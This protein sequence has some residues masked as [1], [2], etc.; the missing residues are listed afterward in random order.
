MKLLP[1]RRAVVLAI[2]VF[3]FLCNQPQTYAQTAWFS[4]DRLTHECLE[5]EGHVYFAI[6]DLKVPLGLSVIFDGE[7]Y[8]VGGTINGTL[9]IDPDSN[10]L[11]VDSGR[12]NFEVPVISRDGLLYLPD[13]LLEAAFGVKVAV[14]KESGEVKL[15]SQVFA[16]TPS[17]D[18][19]RISSSIP[20]TFRT[21]ELDSP[22]R[23]VIDISGAFLRGQMLNVPGGVLGITGLAALR[24][25]QFA[26]EPPV[27]RV[28]LEWEPDSPP[29]HTLF[30]ESKSVAVLVGQNSRPSTSNWGTN[31][32]AIT[33]PEPEIEPVEETVDPGQ[34]D[35]TSEQTF[36]FPFPVNPDP[37]VPFTNP[38]SP[39]P[40]LGPEVPSG[41]SQEMEQPEEPLQTPDDFPEGA[42]NLSLTELGWDF[43]FELDSSGEL[44]ASIGTPPFLSL[45]EFTLAGEGGMRLVINLQGTWLPGD[46][47]A[48]EG[49]Q[50][51]DRIRI[52]QFEQTITRIVLDLNRVVAYQLEFD[53]WEGAITVRLLQGDLSGKTIVIDPGHGGVDPGATVGSVRESD[54][55]MVMA[56]E[57][58]RFL[59]GHGARIVL[60][61]EDD[62]YVSLGDRLMIAHEAN[63]DLFIC[64][65]NNATENETS[66]QGCLIIYNDNEYLRLYRLVHRGIAARTGVPGLGPVE[67]WRGLYLLRHNEGIPVLFIEA[68]FMT[69][70]HDLARLTDP[71]GAYARNIMMGVMDGI[72]A[73]YAG[74]D[75][76]PVSCPDFEHGVSEGIFDLAGRPIV[77]PE[78]APDSGS[79]ESGDDSESQEEDSGSAEE[80]ECEESEEGDENDY[81]ERRGRGAY[82]YD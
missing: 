68:A 67:D 71:S 60:T 56:M 25:S 75:L 19:V 51:I 57:L 24:A 8:L 30:P 40:D 73:F 38:N 6:E 49:L 64:I 66:V 10:E 17:S 26:I 35:E 65:H 36:D 77:P 32:L 81:H 23:R 7:R 12:V 3:A 48:V 22:P 34:P 46:E 79:D 14:N 55:N 31:L 50:E 21:F 5:I 58:K 47:R 69:N 33:V 53:P 41:P 74:R 4:D 59:E 1:P 70:Q 9:S 16:I 29:N 72:L 15:F 18:A 54:L 82:R 63:A 13:T 28:V 45:D 62:S 39:V 52:A 2:A 20:P 78:F 80:D 11:D 61:R 27:V 42:E 76:P 37:D 43:E 44:V